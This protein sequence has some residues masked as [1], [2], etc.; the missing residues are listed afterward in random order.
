MM[1]MKLDRKR[2]AAVHKFRLYLII[3]ENQFCLSSVKLNFPL[4]LRENKKKNDGKKTQH[5]EKQ[6]GL[7]TLGH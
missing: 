1:I 3:K 2:P 6:I 7:L 4:V 5:M